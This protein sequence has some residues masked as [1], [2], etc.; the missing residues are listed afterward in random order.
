MN[1]RPVSR[2]FNKALDQLGN[3]GQNI[4]RDVLEDFKM[5]DS[6]LVLIKGNS[7]PY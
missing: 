5:K 4:E 3:G 2:Q 6:F 1:N 7:N